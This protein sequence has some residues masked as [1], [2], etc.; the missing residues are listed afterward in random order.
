MATIHQAQVA[1][2]N[3][4]TIDRWSWTAVGAGVNTA[5]R[6]EGAATPGTLLV[7]ETL[8]SNLEADWRSERLRAGPPVAITLKG[9]RK[10]VPTRTVTAKSGS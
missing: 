3:I 6:L 9:I 5:A 4:G 7:S 2:G 1:V 8:W 10:P